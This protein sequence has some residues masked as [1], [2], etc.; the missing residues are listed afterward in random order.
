MIRDERDKI[1]RGV[2]TAERA[3][4]ARKIRAELYYKRLDDLTNTNATF[5]NWLDDYTDAYYADIR[6]AERILCMM[7]VCD[8]CRILYEA[9]PSFEIEDH[10]P[11]AARVIRQRHGQ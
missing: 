10:A 4:E 8:E 5:K 9:S 7:H 1:D 3:K 2:D 6:A 11:C